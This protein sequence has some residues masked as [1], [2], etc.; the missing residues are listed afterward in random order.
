MANGNLTEREK[1]Q[2]RLKEAQDSAAAK[3]AEYNEKLVS[4]VDEAEKKVEKTKEDIARAEDR[5]VAAQVRVETLG[6]TLADREALLEKL[7][8]ELKQ[9]QDENA[10]DTDSVNVPDFN[11]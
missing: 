7:T 4:K 6:E 10:L 9:V 5:V 11:A 3:I 8:D 2:A 1:I